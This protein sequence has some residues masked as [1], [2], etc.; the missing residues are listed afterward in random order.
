MKKHS[1]LKIVLGIVIFF[2]SY[3]ALSVQGET[4]HESK[5]TIHLIQGPSSP[6]SSSRE[7]PKEVQELPKTGSNS[8]GDEQIGYVFL[9]LSF[10]LGLIN[11]K[12]SQQNKFYK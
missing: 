8:K 12:R 11:L 4:A 6:S 9:V 10:T 2:A 3:P 7:P 5:V 1:L